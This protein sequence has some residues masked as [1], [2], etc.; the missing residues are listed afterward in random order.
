LHFALLLIALP[1]LLFWDGGPGSWGGGPGLVRQ[2]PPGSGE[3]DCPECLAIAAADARQAARLVLPPLHPRH[4]AHA[5]FGN[6]HLAPRPALGDR[7]GL[8]VTS[9]GHYDP[10]RPDDLLG[11]LPDRLRPTGEAIIP[12]LNYIRVRPTGDASLE[13]AVARVASVARI[14]GHLPEDWLLIHLRAQEIGRLRALPEIDASVPMH[15][16]FKVALNTGRQEF[17]EKARADDPRLR[18]EVFCV[19]FADL[20]ETRRALGRIPGVESAASFGPAGF[21]VRAFHAAV[22]SIARLRDVVWIEESA[23]LMTLN[24]KNAPTVQ[25]GSVEDGLGIRAFDDA[26]V[27]GGG[28]DTNGDGQRLNNESD[29]VPPQIVGVIDNGVSY[30]VPSFAHSA[31]GASLQMPIGTAHRKIHFY[32]PSHGDNLSC[33][34]I[35]SGS[36]THG[37]LVASV[38]AAWP[39]ALGYFAT[40]TKGGIGGSGVPRG[41][42]LDGV[43]R[44][45]RILVQD[46]ATTS[47]CTINSLIEKGGNVDPGRLIDRLNEMIC[48]KSGGAGPCLGRIGGAR[49]IHLA[50]TP[51]GTPDN[52]SVQRILSSSG[53]Y[54]QSAADLDTFLY[55]NR[56]FM[57]VAPVGNSG[58]TVGENRMELV[59]S[60]IP[61]LY[62]GTDRDDCAPQPCTPDSPR[63]LQV[64]APA[65]AKNIIAVG[66][67]RSDCLT[68]F[69]TSDCET[70][71]VD[72]SSHGPATAQS[73]RTVPILTAPASDLI[74]SFETASIAAFRSRDNDNL[75]PL[76]AEIDEGNFGTSFAAA[77]VTGAA[78]LLRDYFAQGF[79][80]TGSRVDGNRVPDV[81]GALV[82]A[83]LVASAK[84]GVRA[85]TTFNHDPIETRFERS[86]GFDQGTVAGVPIGIIGNNT[87]G[88]GRVVLSQVLPLS[89]WP[90]WFAVNPRSAPEFPAPGLLVWDR[91]ATGAPVIGNDAMAAPCTAGAT[92]CARTFR[93]AGPEA[94][95]GAGGG[96]AVWRANLRV[97]L[98]WTDLPS[99][100]GSGGPLVNN[101]DLVVES[102]GPDGCLGAGDTKYDGSGCAAGSEA[103]NLFY[104]GNRYRNTNNA[105]TGQWSES[106]TAA[107]AEVHDFRNPQEAV[108]LASDPDNNF[109]AADASR[110]NDSPLYL[111]TWRA[112]VRVAAGS[113]I[114]GAG[115]ID[116][117]ANRNHRLD[118]G[119]DVDADGLLDLGG[120]DYALVI[121]GPVFQSG[122][123]PE[124]G[125]QG[126]PSARIA[127]DR[128]RV[129]CSDAPRATVFD[130][131]GGSAALGRD[132]TAFEVRTANG[133]ILDLEEGFGFAAG[134]AAGSFRS[135]P[136]PVRLAG[137]T[138]V[139]RNGILEADTGDRVV[140]TYARS[141]AVAVSAAAPVDCTPDLVPAFFT[142]VDGWAFDNQVV[143]G[144]GCDGDEYPDAGET[145]TYGI[146]LH[147]HSRLDD[148]TDVI[149]TL[150]ASGTGGAAVRVVDSPQ[151][152]GRFPAG[153]GQAV[154]FHLYVDPAAVNSLPAVDRKV[155]LTLTLESSARGQRI[156]RQSY[157]FTHALNSDK[158]TFHYSTD[159]PSGGR[160]VRDLNRNLSIDAADRVDPVLGIMLPDEEIVFSS[161][162]VAGDA[163]DRVTNTL[164]EDLNGNG[165]RDPGES[166]LVPDGSLTHGILAQAAGPSEGDVVPFDFEDGPDGWFPVRHPGGTAAASGGFPGTPLWERQ[167]SGI[168]GFQ[169]SGPPAG[170]QAAVFGIWHTGDG[171]ATTPSAGAVA[172]D[173]HAMPDPTTFEPR[174]VFAMDV[175]LSPIVAKVRQAP[176]ARGFPFEVEFQR[177][178]WNLNMQVR[179]AAYAGGG[180]NIDSDLGT[181][182]ENCLLCQQ[183]D[184][185]YLRRFGGWPYGVFGFT[186]G[187][188][189]AGGEGIDP[190]STEPHQRTFGPFVDPDRSSRV[191]I[192]DENPGAPCTSDAAC[193]SPYISGGGVC[194]PD[195]P[196]LPGPFDLSG[197]ES[198]FSGFTQNTNF[199]SRSPIPTAQ[200]DFLPYPPPGAPLPGLCLS[201]P[202]AGAPCQT[203]GD[204]GP[205]GACTLEDNTGA[206]P[207]RSFDTSLVNFEGGSAHVL[208]AGLGAPE[209]SFYF[210]PGP[211][212]DRWQM[213]IGFFTIQATMDVRDYGFAVDDVVFEWDESHPAEEADLGRPPACSRFGGAG[214]PAGTQCATITVDRSVLYECEES[215]RITVVDPSATT[216]AVTVQIV[217]SGD[218]VPFVSDRFSVLAPD[219]KTYTLERI[220]AIPPTYQAEVVFTAAT[221]VPGQV[222]V[223]AGGRGPFVVYY[224]DPDCDADRDGSMAESLFT[225][226]DGD[227]VADSAD[228]CPFLYNP[229][230]ED[231][232]GDG[233]GDLCDNCPLMANTD[234]R[235][236]DA[237]GVGDACDHDDVDGDGVSET[238]GDN[239]PGLHQDTL[240]DADLDGR[241]D[242][243]DAAVCRNAPAI[244]CA[245]DADCPRRCVTT[246][247]R[248]CT[249]DADCPFGEVCSTQRGDCR[250]L[251][252]APD[253]DR[254]GVG[255]VTDNCILIPNPL[256][257]DSDA[258]RLG[259]ACD[260]D[261]AAPVVL[262]YCS[263]VRP[264]T[265]CTPGVTDCGHYCLDNPDI[266]C[267]GGD[268]ALCVNGG[269]CQPNTCQPVVAPAP[270]AVCSMVNDDADIDG[271]ADVLDNC[272]TVANPAIIPLTAKQADRDSDGLGDA[273]DPAGSSDD[274]LD[275]VPDDVITFHGEI[276]CDA[277]PLA[278]FVFVAADYRDLDGDHDEFPD[279][280]ETG[281][282]R[283]MLQNQ[284]RDAAGRPAALTG[285]VFTLTSADPDVGCIVRSTAT[286]GTIGSGETVVLGVLPDE[287]G[288]G[289][290]G[291]TFR[292]SDNLQTVTPAAPPD[293]EACVTAQANETSA[294][295]APVCFRILADLDLPSGYQQVFTP[296]PDGVAGTPDDGT[297][298]ETFD[299]DLDGDGN[300]TVQDTFRRTDE[301]TG[302]VVHGSYLYGSETG[303]GANVM[304]GV[305]CGGYRTVEE[306]NPA[307][308]LDPDFPMDWHLHCAP[309]ATDCPNL[310]SGSGNSIGLGACVGGC[311]YRTPA[312]GQRALSPA[313]SLHMGAHFDLMDETSGDTT[314]LRALQAFVSAPI[315]LAFLPRP[316]DLQLSMFHIA[317]LMEDTWQNLICLDCADVQVRL[318][319]DPDP[320]ND[321]WGVWDKLVPFQN[322]Y[323]SRPAAWSVYGAYYCLFTPGDT[324]TA[325]PNPHGVHE[326]MCYPQGAWSKC[327]S[328]RG[329]T[330]ATV[331]DCKSATGVLD[332]V[333]HGV[334][335]ETRF[336]LAPFMG[337]RIQVRWIGSSWMLDAVSSS[338]WEV[339]GGWGGTQL[340]DG[341]WL[342]NITFTG[343][344][345]RQATPYPDL[346]PAPPTS[347]PVG[348]DA[349]VGDN[350]TQ[351]ALRVTDLDNR[352]I[353][354]ATN[355]AVAGRALRITAIDSALP[356]GCPGGTPQ[357]EFTRNGLVAQ[358]WSGRAWLQD[359]PVSDTMYGVRVRCGTDH[360]CTSAQ[361]AMLT[362]QVYGGAGDDLRLSIV[363]SRETGATHI[364]WVARPQPAPLSGYGLFRGL[365][366]DDGDT[367]TPAGSDPTLATLAPLACDLPGVAPGS[368]V[369]VTTSD[370]PPVG[371]ILYYLAGHSHPQEGSRAALGLDSAGRTRIAPIACP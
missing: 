320:A 218:S 23:E 192:G 69:L 97:A 163:A 240:R 141:G 225:N 335:V 220:A 38:I 282:L 73:L 226:H 134:P 116:E 58:G 278:S 77:N 332:P 11:D 371:S 154:F 275:G 322:V 26:G 206:G 204:C 355:V 235:D 284:S 323:E 15:P 20:E 190:Y 49:E 370:A 155:T 294:T 295:A 277:L 8:L 289:G 125:P 251:I 160:E 131:A 255:D 311:S 364:T 270:P 221:D 264:L 19:P 70:R 361:G 166:D 32:D 242:A 247:T 193:D 331:A 105:I 348:C 312:N 13:Q 113:S 143:L 281:I 203:G 153:V 133:A 10:A 93:V 33:D 36:G 99:P 147:N 186:G 184:P 325:P 145:V 216:A 209:S 290:Y 76:E 170:G 248:A 219:Q 172:C 363:H 288:Q 150:T 110:F 39:G 314:H 181:D 50:V 45:A 293:I 366:N 354:D 176:D 215:L 257:Q 285:T 123:L 228:N 85:A 233:P 128:F 291:F 352:P 185:Y 317:D 299:L 338:Y 22:P 129:T 229:D 106:R 319:Q 329:T 308:R 259:D 316:G 346:D 199:D 300:F 132:A 156:G 120:Q 108:H 96:L 168:C 214:Q 304:A 258:D 200:P 9:L 2:A 254:D 236:F 4:P 244:A 223:D 198:G 29:A 301:G 245:S 353:D 201:G 90:H 286:V 21:Q 178:G 367:G 253:T 136:V 3:D 41:A 12:G 43:A 139:P 297:M 40:R 124:G 205:G 175:L 87:Q 48:P 224:P 231:P 152:V 360:D 59:L 342:D 315:N 262:R 303:I 326:T 238:E 298:R 67:S 197:D 68:F 80:P 328:V 292:A 189:F 250:G 81:S 35:L 52:F 196:S 14:V 296:G 347:C 115:G 309:G 327:G 357:F 169:T 268:A 208:P 230:Q 47:R 243:C 107:Q 109:S 239:C 75:W 351:P 188:Y 44:G 88:Y 318:D 17:L 130:P 34:A 213:G 16:A 222:Q 98:A 267:P 119:E 57:V 56:D 252:T 148:Y 334:W 111:G 63:P 237:D 249:T 305:P 174:A 260:G 164:G 179:N 313:N 138:R 151:N 126:F 122:P 368:E 158:E 217:T 341:W 95:A 37:T 265:A 234:Q 307:C 53:T 349:G 283:V 71:V 345:T 31:A 64:A 287:A 127:L 246:A 114:A 241:G 6:R 74:P 202:M 344:L 263:N 167:T 135:D 104:D 86:R 340:D 112:T 118:P 207:V 140:V 324:G 211:A 336:D 142:A 350:G 276:A 18:L 330:T 171:N 54:P 92:A 117:D 273:C 232:D 42:N 269:G 274:D 78:A 46:V 266:S 82:K 157:S 24:A 144:N 55:N 310:E 103:D 62:N 51:F 102:P 165:V 66:A 343:A 362:V 1:V 83:A 173:N 280:G 212:G 101:L 261:C 194:S 369:I 65:T 191:C 180:I 84:F 149:A 27:D 302:T 177:S 306:G 91:V 121:A 279:T 7:R 72:F 183:L 359:A 272:P 5:V 159:F 271:V 94:G 358:A 79:Y 227:G 321:L 60:E 339:G 146:S 30:D 89:N 337:Q 195:N 210:T 256:Q 100:A 356:G 61:D 187:Q 162:F 182:N 28:I 161:L 25:V 333:G 365:M 137:A